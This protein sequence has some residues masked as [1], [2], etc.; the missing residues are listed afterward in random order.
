[1]ELCKW[2]K[3]NGGSNI[4]VDLDLPREIT[5]FSIVKMASTLIAT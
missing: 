1:M 2:C 4:R 3:F 5:T